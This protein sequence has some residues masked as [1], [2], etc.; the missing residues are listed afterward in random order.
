[1]NRFVIVCKGLSPIMH[2]VAILKPTIN[3]SFSI[4]NIDN[5]NNN[6][7]RIVIIV[8]GRISGKERDRQEILIPARNLAIF[9]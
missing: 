4:K 8:H 5:N 7:H 1:M 6:K 9:Q 3:L 2:E